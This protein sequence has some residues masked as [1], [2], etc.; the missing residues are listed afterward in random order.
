M[1]ES[2]KR[3]HEETRALLHKAVAAPYG[4]G[5][6]LVKAAGYWDDGAPGDDAHSDDDAL[7]VWDVEVEVSIGARATLRIE[8]E[9]PEQA[10]KLGL[11]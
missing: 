10:K 5:L 2:L 3:R 1:S 9:T 8:A 6:D 7:P 4:S 11:Y